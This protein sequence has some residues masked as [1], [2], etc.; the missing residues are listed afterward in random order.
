M[1][2]D[3]EGVVED[4]RN[5]EEE[6]FDDEDSEK[7]LGKSLMLKLSRPEVEWGQPDHVS[8]WNADHIKLDI[9]NLLF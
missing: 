1:L 7:R 5:L 3:W 9:Y 4:L 8:A 6:A 2:K